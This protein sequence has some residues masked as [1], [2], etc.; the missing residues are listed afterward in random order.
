MRKRKL[1]LI[2]LV[3]AVVVVAVALVFARRYSS[4]IR[5]LIEGKKTVAQRL[6]E[7]GPAARA[8]MR[9]DFEKAKVPYPPAEVT[10][11]GIKDA[12]RLEVYAR[13]A[14]HEWRF[15]TWYSIRAAS[16]RAGPKL[17]EG[18]RQV[19][20]GIYEIESLNPN[21][22]FHLSLRVG[23]PNKFDREKANLDGREKLGGD[24]MIHG[25]SSSVGCL[26]MGDEVAEDLFVL[27][28][29]VGIEKVKVILSPTDFRSAKVVARQGGPKWTA[30]LYESIAVEMK[31]LP[32]NGVAAIE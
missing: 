27:A 28:A 30:E 10:L 20:E 16:G 17:R 18:D 31:K 21:S 9:A 2:T 26:A 5:N 14:S 24:I 1:G 13:D 11:L 32:A 25:R 15:V 8:R 29:D 3:L 19:P 6:E 7:H 4:L 23:Y 22:M 12:K